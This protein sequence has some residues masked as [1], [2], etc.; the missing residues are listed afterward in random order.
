MRDVE[1]RHRLCVVMA[2]ARLV[3]VCQGA[4]VVAAG[5]RRE[6]DQQGFR[7]LSY[8]RIGGPWRRRASVRGLALIRTLVLPT[9]RDPEPAKASRRQADRSRW[10][11]NMPRR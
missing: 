6:V 10:M 7:G 1:A 8:A 5:R 3:L 11:D 4:E 2:A 9:A